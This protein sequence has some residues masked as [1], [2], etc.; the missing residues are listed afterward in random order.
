M[1]KKNCRIYIVEHPL[2]RTFSS[3]ETS[4]FPCSIR[5]A[6]LYIRAVQL[7]TNVR[8]A[9]NQGQFWFDWTLWSII[10]TDGDEVDNCDE[11]DDDGKHGDDGDE[12][13]VEWVWGKSAVGAGHNHPTSAN[14]STINIISIVVIDIIYI[15]INIVTTIIVIID[16]ITSTTQRVLSLPLHDESQRSYL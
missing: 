2:F 16:I 6:I 9:L 15:I 12:L 5:A 10:K 7:L 11:A 4:F 8:F 14:S 13:W 3:K 1:V